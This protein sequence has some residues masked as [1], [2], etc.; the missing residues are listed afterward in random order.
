MHAAP[1]FSGSQFSDQVIIILFL[2]SPKA[3]SVDAENEHA[4][5]AIRTRTEDSLSL[6]QPSRKGVTKP[7]PSTDGS[8]PVLGILKKC[9]CRAQEILATSQPLSEW[10]QLFLRYELIG[11]RILPRNEFPSKLE[12]GRLVEFGDMVKPKQD[13]VLGSPARLRIPLSPGADKPDRYGHHRKRVP[14]VT[15]R[16]RPMVIRK[17]LIIR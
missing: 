8:P 7:G 11:M 16:I 10:V 2:N 6:R 12:R 4:S 15:Q 17:L 13:F 3:S 5:E 9:G 1:P 14:V